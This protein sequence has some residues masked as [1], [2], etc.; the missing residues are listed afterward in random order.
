M[1]SIDGTNEC[2]KSSHLMVCDTPILFHK[3]LLNDFK[4]VEKVEENLKIILRRSSE[5][6]K[7]IMKG[8]YIVDSMLIK[9]LV[10]CYISNLL[11]NR[12]KGRNNNYHKNEIL[13]VSYFPVSLCL[14]FQ[15]LNLPKPYEAVLTCKYNLK[16]FTHSF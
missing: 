13:H 4:L 1:M 7:N 5:E 16:N 8:A 12:P 10:I 14:Y 2:S 11:R 15:N 3:F 6:C 9:I